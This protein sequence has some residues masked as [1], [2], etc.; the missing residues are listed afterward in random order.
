MTIN[1]PANARIS[2]S[3]SGK[4]LNATTTDYKQLLFPVT[5]PEGMG[6]GKSETI[7]R[8]SEE[9]NG[10]MDEFLSLIR[11]SDQYKELWQTRNEVI[12]KG[13]AEREETERIANNYD[14]NNAQEIYTAVKWHSKNNQGWHA[15]DI[16]TEGNA[17]TK[18][19]VQNIGSFTATPY[20]NGQILM[21]GEKGKL[22]LFRFVNTVEDRNYHRLLSEIVE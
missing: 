22:K 19:I 10:T 13:K 1:I 17:L 8:T 21:K 7:Y 11:E 4:N 20:D 5:I 16:L 15:C 6:W 2:F 14:K 9:F 18:L 3:K 12:A